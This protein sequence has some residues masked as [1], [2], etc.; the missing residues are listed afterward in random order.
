[1][2]LVMILAIVFG[3][4]LIAFVQ[5]ELPAV[6]FWNITGI[7]ETLRLFFG[8]TILSCLILTPIIGRIRIIEMILK[9]KL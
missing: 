8:A 4:M 5:M 1:M 3:W 2:F 6:D 7:W 9:R